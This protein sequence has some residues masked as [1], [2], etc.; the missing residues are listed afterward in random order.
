MPVHEPGGDEEGRRDPKSLQEGEGVPMI[1]CE[2]I[3]ER[4]GHGWTPSL[5]LV[6]RPHG[7]GEGD[8]VASIAQPLHMT[9]ER[10]RTCRAREVPDWI[11]GV[12]AEHRDA[13]SRRIERR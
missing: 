8:D 10:A 6:T 5:H 2:R 12:I 13:S 11:D 1:V 3:I 7:L 4:D 9:L